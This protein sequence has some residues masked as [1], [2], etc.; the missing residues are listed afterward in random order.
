MQAGRL[1]H[2]I[3]V[4]HP[5]TKKSSFGDTIIEWEKKCCTRA[6]VIYNNANKGEQVGEMFMSYEVTF[7]VRRYHNIDEFDI[8]RFKDVDWRINSI[9]PQDD[10]QLINIRASRVN[11]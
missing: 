6:N 5:V 8:I 9:E 11:E 10:M 2:I 4:K 3:E 1:K 7:Q